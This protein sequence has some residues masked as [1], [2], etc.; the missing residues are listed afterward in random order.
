[1]GWV[2]INIIP[3]TILQNSQGILGRTVIDIHFLFNSIIDIF[4]LFHSDHFD[5]ILN[6]CTKRIFSCVSHCSFVLRFSQY[7]V[8]KVF[9]T[10][11][12]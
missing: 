5:S 8:M 4:F 7:K 11:F 2:L 1:M 6:K 10:I 3:S 12:D 9:S